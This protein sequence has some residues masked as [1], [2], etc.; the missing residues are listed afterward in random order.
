MDVPFLLDCE[1][2]Q[3]LA[4]LGLH[5]GRIVAQPDGIREPCEPPLIRALR[6]RDVGGIG[7]SGLVPV[8]VVRDA[9]F[10]ASRLE[11]GVAAEGGNRLG[12]REQHVMARQVGVSAHLDVWPARRLGACAVA[13]HLRCGVGVG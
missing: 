11:L 8:A 10:G 5:R 12:M 4:Q 7:A 6:R 3:A 2:R 1:L 9:N 13:E